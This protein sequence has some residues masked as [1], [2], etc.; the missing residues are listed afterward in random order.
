M[1]GEFFAVIETNEIGQ[2]T[3]DAGVADATS[4]ELGGERVGERCHDGER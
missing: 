3:L 4:I 1:V 2:V